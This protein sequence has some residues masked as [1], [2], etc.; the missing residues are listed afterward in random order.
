MSLYREDLNEGDFFV[1]ARYMRLRRSQLNS[2]RKIL[3]EM[4]DSLLMSSVLLTATALFKASIDSKRK[5]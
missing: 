4:T 1:I 2:A 3:V 5:N